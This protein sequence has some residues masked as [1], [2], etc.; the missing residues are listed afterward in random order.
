MLIDMERVEV[1]RGPQGTYFGRNSLGGALNLTT[2]APTDE[3]EG[4]VVLGMESYEDAGEMYNVTGIFNAPLSDAFK[5][6][7]VAFYEDSDGL[8][9]NIGP[10]TGDSGHEWL[11]LR[12]RAVWDLSDATSLG[13][14]R[15]LLGPGPGH[16]RERA[17]GHRRPRHDRYLRIPARSRLRSRHRVL[18][19]Q[20]EQA[21]PRSRRV[22][23]ARNDDRHRESARTRFPTA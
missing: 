8:V 22:E 6:R 2:Q 10:G 12:L 23:R 20:P 16:G 14:T 15:D 18:A 21:E 17:L 4:E 5:V 13:F 9:E 11:D 1:L 3:Y 19:G 7:A